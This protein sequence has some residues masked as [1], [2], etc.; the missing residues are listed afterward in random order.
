MGTV[1]LMPWST[2]WTP[3]VGSPTE[4]FWGGGVADSVVMRFAD[5]G[6]RNTWLNPPKGAVCVMTN[7]TGSALPTMWMS[8]GGSSGNWQQI[9]PPILCA[10]FTQA[11]TI[12]SALT[13]SGRLSLTNANQG[14]DSND[15]VTVGDMNTSL[16][17]Y[18]PL[19]GSVRMT[20]WLLL[21]MDPF[22][23]DQPNAAT[24]AKYVN[25]VADLKLDKTGGTLTGSL[26]INDH[27]NPAKLLEFNVGNWG[28]NSDGCRMTN[29]GTFQSTVADKNVPSITLFRRLDAGDTPGQYFVRFYRGAP[30]SSPVTIGSITAGKQDN[31]DAHVNRVFYNT[32]S[33]Y[34]MKERTGPISD[35]AERVLRLASRAFRG[36]W[37]G[38]VSDEDMMNAHDIAEAAPYAVLGDKDAV[39]P[40]GRIDP[41]QVDYSSL[42]TLLTA[43]LGNALDRIGTLE[44]RLA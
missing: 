2:V 38:N 31:D 25:A 26:T 9:G 19:D 24:P 12:A 11:Q 15:A 27:A 14:N 33:D 32:T 16:K 4:A 22:P 10:P 7:V 35:A 23:T 13:I 6:Q 37:Q 8:M 5:L 44:A 42:V 20:D 17:K 1:Q 34:R 39:L 41:Q 40:D 18:V 3:V 28:G 36:H 29:Q 30:Q 43:A 21:P